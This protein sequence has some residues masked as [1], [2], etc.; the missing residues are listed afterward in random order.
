MEILSSFTLQ[1]AR[2]SP[3][4][5][6]SCFP[7]CVVFFICFYL[8]NLWTNLEILERDGEIIRLKPFQFFEK[9]RQKIKL[10]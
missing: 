2:L 9:F 7:L 4:D 10:S 3:M 5:L 1:E 6:Y 8:V